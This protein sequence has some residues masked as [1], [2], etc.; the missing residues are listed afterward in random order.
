MSRPDAP[1]GGP[2]SSDGSRTSV[3]GTPFAVPAARD[4]RALATATALLAGR[5]G[6]LDERD[7]GGSLAFAGFLLSLLSFVTVLFVGLPAL[8]LSSC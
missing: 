3:S 8:V 7:S 1:H 6:D 2:S 5:P 4:R